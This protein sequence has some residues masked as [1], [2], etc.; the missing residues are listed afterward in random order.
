MA[1]PNIKSSTDKI[2]DSLTSKILDSFLYIFGGSYKDPLY[3]YFTHGSYNPTFTRQKDAHQRLII[4]TESTLVTYFTHRWA[5]HLSSLERFINNKIK[6]AMEFS[7]FLRTALHFM[8]LKH[9]LNIQLQKFKKNL[10]ITS[11]LLMKFSTIS[12]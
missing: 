1:Y 2:V 12:L 5:Y 7:I 9:R 3:I 10:R 8:L 11:Y 4:I 6:T